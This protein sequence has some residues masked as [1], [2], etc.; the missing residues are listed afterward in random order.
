MNRTPAPFLRA[1][2]LAGG[3]IAARLASAADDPT[4]TAPSTPAEAKVAPPYLSPQESAK[5]VQLPPGY[6]LELV[7]REPDIREPVVG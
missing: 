7:L 2:V 5:L 1:L 4:A 6:H 3:L